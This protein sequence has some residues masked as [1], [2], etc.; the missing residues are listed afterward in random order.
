MASIDYYNI[1]PETSS[2]RHVGYLFGWLCL[3]NSACV[4]IFLLVVAVAI[5][6]LKGFRF[7]KKVSTTS[8]PR[9]KSQFL[10]K[11]VFNRLRDPSQF[12]FESYGFKFPVTVCLYIY[13]ICVAIIAIVSLVLKRVLEPQDTFVFLSFLTNCSVI[14]LTVYYTIHAVLG[15]FYFI[16]FN[17]FYHKTVGIPKLK[18]THSRMVTVMRGISNAIWLMGEL[19]ISSTVLICIGYWILTS[20]ESTEPISTRYFNIYFHAITGILSLIDFFLSNMVFRFW[21]LFIS[22]LFPAFYIFWLLLIVEMRWLTVW[23]YSP[24]NYFMMPWL[25]SSTFL[26]FTYLAYVAIFAFFVLVSKIRTRILI[27]WILKDIEHEE[28][29][30]LK[31][32]QDQEL[33]MTYRSPP[34][35][36]EISPRSLNSSSSRRGSISSPLVTPTTTDVTSPSI[37]ERPNIFSKL[38][39]ADLTPEEFGGNV[40]FSETNSSTHSSEQASTSASNSPL[41]ISAFT[42]PVRFQTSEERLNSST[43]L[44]KSV[45]T[46]NHTN[47]FSGNLI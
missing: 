27:R 10:K 13:R 21:H 7:H 38:T 44:L 18:K 30:L 33:A 42:A 20:F 40:E 37:F 41:T 22:I 29:E 19:S 9:L 16:F 17:K 36:T 15:M 43:T 45:L 28:T 35:N 11:R 26:F 4:M 34:V 3:V 12:I 14:I 1:L 2:D 8:G 24:V 47:S 31:Q 25:A 5:Y 23:P 6:T 46:K 39:I 32:A